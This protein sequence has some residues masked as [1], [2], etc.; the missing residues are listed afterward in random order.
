VC[1]QD[2]DCTGIGAG[3]CEVRS[4]FG[5]NTTCQTCTDADN[6]DFC[7]DYDCN[8]SNPLV[9]PATRWYKDLDGDGYGDNTFVVQCA[10]PT[11]YYLS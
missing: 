6:D 1:S 7:S 5:C 3:M 8:E 11:D 9:N 2:S 4:V 10:Q